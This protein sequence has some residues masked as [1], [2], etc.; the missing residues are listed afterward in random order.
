MKKQLLS[1]LILV[2]IVTGIIGTAQSETLTQEFTSQWYVEPWDYNGEI[3]TARW[4][5]KPYTTAESPLER[6]EI[7]FSMEVTGLSVG[8]D[9][10]YS[11]E[12]ATD[13]YTGYG[14]GQF[15]FG[16]SFSQVTGST[17]IIKRDYEITTPEALDKWFNPPNI[18]NAYF[19]L[20]TGT[21]TGPY[22]VT[23]KTVLT[24]YYAE[25]EVAIDIVPGDSE[26]TINIKNNKP[27]EVAILTSEAFDASGIDASTVTF[28]PDSA[29]CFEDYSMEDVDH[30]GDADMV[31]RFDVQATGIDC[32]C[33]TAELTGLTFAGEE[34]SSQGRVNVKPCN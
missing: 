13:D 11:H 22:T 20:E 3:T 17:L 14:S 15:R 34:F 29:L 10:R 8:D 1:G 30:D 23:S 5:Y 19:Y 18:D 28:G 33:D 21:A 27:L 26:N 12:F 6:F 32:T 31:L 4:D 25:P 7:S 2:F 16:D 24:Y 9:F